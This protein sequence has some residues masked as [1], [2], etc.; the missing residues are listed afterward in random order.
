MCHTQGTSGDIGD[1]VITDSSGNVFVTGEFLGTVDFGVDFGTSDS[2]TST[3]SADIFIT[4][5]KN[6]IKAMSHITGGGIIENLPRVIPH[7]LSAKISK[8]A[9]QTP[10]IFNFMSTYIQEKEMFRTF[11]MGVG[12]ILIVKEENVDTIL[13]KSDGYVIGKLVKKIKKVSLV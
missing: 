2:K 4:K 10:H 3:G 13:A 5:I 7:N 9:I 1:S 6:N 11:N 8:N 12:M